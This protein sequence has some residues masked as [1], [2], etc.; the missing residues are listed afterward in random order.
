MS[1]LDL[2]GELRNHI[3]NLLIPDTSK[4]Y[5]E[6]VDLDPNL[7]PAL[8]VVAFIF[9]CK[10]IQ[11]ELLPLY[12]RTINLRL[13]YNDP[14]WPAQCVV[15]RSTY[16]LMKAY[17]KMSPTIVDHLHSILLELCGITCVIRVTNSRAVHVE[18]LT[19]VQWITST[20]LTNMSIGIRDQITDSLVNSP[21]GLL[22]IRHLTIAL[23][24]I[25]QIDEWFEWIDEEES[26]DIEIVRDVPW[27]SS[28]SCG[29]CAAYKK[30]LVE[31][32]EAEGMPRLIL[33]TASLQDE[34]EMY[35]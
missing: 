14:P 10:E 3:Y 24:T 20:V 11:R 22:G 15:D 9:T 31:Q 33:A 4:Y 16:D 17:E 27:H 30:Y 23:Q 35:D 28:N 6:V 7:P 34:A 2:P 26:R 13:D 21:T 5:T 19:V 29:C 25:V 12:F 1:F 18:L 8:P 32:A